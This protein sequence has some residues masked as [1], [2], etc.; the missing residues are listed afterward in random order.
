MVALDPANAGA[1]RANFLSFSQ[2][3]AA[4][5]TD[6]EDRLHALKD[7]PFLVLHDAFQYFEARYHVS[8]SGA[9][10][11]GDGAQPGPARLAKLRDQLA[12]N[13]VKCAFAEPAHNAA[14]IEALMAGEGVEVVTLN[15][16]GD[17][18]LPMTA[19][20]PALVQGMADAIVGCLAKP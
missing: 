8:A 9:V 6:L 16:M 5:S 2:E 12:A 14:L 7:I 11:L 4:L 19:P 17:P 13:P 15:P 1:Y 10:F 20:Y 3:L 18:D